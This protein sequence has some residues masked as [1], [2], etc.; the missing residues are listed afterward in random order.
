MV[1]LFKFNSTFRL[2]VNESLELCVFPPCT[3]VLRWR[4]CGS[5]AA[6]IAPRFVQLAAMPWCCWWIRATLTC[7]T[8]STVSSTSCPLPGTGNTQKKHLQWV[9]QQSALHEIICSYTLQDFSNVL[10]FF[11]YLHFLQ[12][13]SSVGHH[14]SFLTMQECFEA[15]IKCLPPLIKASEEE[16]IAFSLEPRLN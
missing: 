15:F 6:A 12:F 2:N 10:E 8:S 13:V 3:R 9:H 5:S 11:I 4:L 7:T 16:A 1:H 14:L